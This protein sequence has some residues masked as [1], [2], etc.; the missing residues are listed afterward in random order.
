VLVIYGLVA[1]EIVAVSTGKLPVWRIAPT[2][3]LQAAL[4][5]LFAGGFHYAMLQRWR[6][7]FARS[8]RS[9]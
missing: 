3:M 5:A 1:T 6:A 2:W 4:L 7:R 9:H 8:A